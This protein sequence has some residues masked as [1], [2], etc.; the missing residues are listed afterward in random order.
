[1]NDRIFEALKCAIMKSIKFY[2]G[3]LWLLV[4]FCFASCKSNQ[5]PCSD[6]PTVWQITGKDSSYYELYLDKEKQILYTDYLD[7]QGV[8]DSTLCKNPDF[9]QYC[10]LK[11]LYFNCCTYKEFKKAA[12]DLF[13]ASFIEPKI[14]SAD[15]EFKVV[16]YELFTGDDLRKLERA[17]D[18]AAVK[19]KIDYKHPNR[20]TTLNTKV[21]IIEED[22]K[23]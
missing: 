19:R 3:V 20:D 14:N 1:M 4:I 17:F 6:P 13:S 7:A 2:T 22:V 21:I 8:Y 10:K 11:P 12:M 15:F 23:R 18:K 16:S 9:A 5:Q